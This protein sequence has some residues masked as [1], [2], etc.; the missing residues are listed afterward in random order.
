MGEN[1]NF[2]DKIIYS[3]IIALTINTSYVFAEKSNSIKNEI[4]E[5]KDKIQSLEEEKSNINNQ[6]EKNQN[7]MN[8]YLSFK[9]PKDC[10]ITGDTEC[11][12][13]E[14]DSKKI[15]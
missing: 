14:E 2:K 5:N 12:R 15:K 8:W 1:M 13:I 9:N 4:N 3:V 6:I 10:K 11:N 7:G